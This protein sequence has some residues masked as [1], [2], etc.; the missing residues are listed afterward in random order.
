MRYTCRRSPPLTAKRFA[1]VVAVLT[2]CWL[3]FRPGAHL[4]QPTRELAQDDLITFISHGEA[5]KL[6]DHVQRT[7]WTVVEFGADW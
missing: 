7:G 1:V 4:R 6:D 3:V 5:V 2:A